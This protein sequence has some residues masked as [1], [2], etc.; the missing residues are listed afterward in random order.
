MQL[1]LVALYSSLIA[2]EKT[3]IPI[4]EEHFLPSTIHPFHQLR[5]DIHRTIVEIQLELGCKAKRVFGASTYSTYFDLERQD[6]ALP[7]HTQHSDG[8]SDDGSPEISRAQK[9]ED[10]EVTG[11]GRLR[12]TFN[13]SASDDEVDDR[14]RAVSERLQREAEIAAPHPADPDTGAENTVQD[15]ETASR[16]LTQIASGTISTGSPD[17][18]NL[19][20]KPKGCAR[21][22][23]QHFKVS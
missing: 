23:V 8:I 17:H 7:T 22:L 15:S 16:L 9:S 1:S 10:Q 14:L 4:F 13:R 2:A 18:H 5:R 11:V 20:F 6:D 3:P 21:R 12:P 19:P